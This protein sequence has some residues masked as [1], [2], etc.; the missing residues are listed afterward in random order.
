MPKR[1]STMLT[2][3]AV[4]KIGKAP[5]GKR[6]ERFDAGQ[7]GLSIRIT[8]RGVKSW[9][10]YYHLAE[11][12]HRMTIGHWPTVGVKAARIKAAEVKEQVN[13]GI[14]PKIALEAQRIAAR[15]A[16]QIEAERHKTFEYIAEQFIKRGMRN[17]SDR[18]R[19]DIE[20]RIRSRLLPA[21]GDRSCRGLGLKDAH[22]LF[23]Y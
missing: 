6:I 9:S 18:F 2:D 5:P 1:N 8:E 17:V 4:G 20:A 12:H 13:A 14:D 15:E 23:N 3:A 22:R 10:V 16:A 7:P 11:K 19:R 21:W